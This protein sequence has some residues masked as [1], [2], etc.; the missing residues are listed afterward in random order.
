[1]KSPLAVL[2]LSAVAAFGQD[3]AP[4]NDAK[5]APSVNQFKLQVANLAMQNAQLSAHIEGLQK[6]LESTRAQLIQLQTNAV[7]SEICSAA[8]IAPKECSI[9]QDGTASKA[10]PPAPSPAKAPD[11]PAAAAPAK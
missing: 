8:G 3:A 11:A 10:A 4:A 1:M 5:P 7:V 6:E 2:L 9:A